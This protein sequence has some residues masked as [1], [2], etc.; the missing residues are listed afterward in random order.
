MPIAPSYLSTQL[1]IYENDSNLRDGNDQNQKYEEQETE[2]VIKLILPNCCENEEQF[3]EHGTKGKDSSHQ[4]TIE[5]MSHTN[6][7]HTI[8]LHSQTRKY[9]SNTSGVGSCTTAEEELVEG[10]GWFGPDVDMVS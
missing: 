6:I 8:L 5:N 10:F 4:R 9:Q 2:H 3:D 1:K 7:Q